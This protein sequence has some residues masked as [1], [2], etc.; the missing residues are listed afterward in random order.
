MAV[1]DS[2]TI[3]F[4]SLDPVKNQAVLTISDHL[5][6]NDSLTHQLI[7]QDKLNA[8]LRFVEGGELIQNFPK[9]LGLPIVFNVWFLHQPDSEGLVF[10]EK[11][12]EVIESAGFTLSFKVGLA[13]PN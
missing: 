13:K 1:D 8:Y 9:Y 10:L 5:D 11:A 6:W 2:N 12:R 3:D 7:L 4:V